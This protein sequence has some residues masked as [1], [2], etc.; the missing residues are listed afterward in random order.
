MKRVD[1]F[2]VG[3]AWQGN[4]DHLRDEQRSAPLAAFE[5]LAKVPGVRLVSLQQ[6]V[7]RKQLPELAGPLGVLDFADQVEDFADTAAIVSNLDMVISVDTSVAHLAG[8][9]GLPVWVAIQFLPDGG[10]CW[11]ARIAPGIPPCGFSA[12]APGR[13]GRRLRAHGRS[14]TTAR[15]WPRV[16]A[17]KPIK[18]AGILRDAGLLLDRFRR[19]EPLAGLFGPRNR[20]ARAASR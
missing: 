6:G 5:P 9:M 3:I 8:A 20:S 10:G 13:L 4:P 18:L 1:G 14:S 17:V 2:K 12:S 16:N 7:G 19:P 11:S 15:E